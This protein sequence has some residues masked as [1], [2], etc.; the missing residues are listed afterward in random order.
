M[1]DPLAEYR[2]KRR[3]RRTPEPAGDAVRPGRDEL[4]VIQ[5]HHARR[6]HWDV[7][8]ERGGVLVSWAVPKGLPPEPGTVRLAVHTEDH[9][10]EYADFDGEIPAGE[11][12]A[13]TVTIWDRGRYETVKWSTDEVS[14]VLHGDRVRG[15][16]VFFR[17]HRGRG[18]NS[19]SDEWLVRRSDPPQQPDWEPLPESLAP[20]LASAGG[21]PPA[22]RD[23]EWAY[24]FKWDGVRALVRV[25]GGRVTVFSRKG[26]D[27]T[28]SY[29]ELR[30]LGEAMGSTQ[31]MLDG[32]IVAL[33]GGRPNFAALQRRMHV[34]SEASARRLAETQ[35]VTYL[36]FD[37]LHLQGRSLL[38]LPYTERRRQLEG[39]GLA[40]PRWQTPRYFAG[41]GAAVLHASREQGLEGVMAKRLSSPYQAGRRSREWVKVAHLRAQEV[42]I[43]G[44]RPGQGRRAGAIGSLLCGVPAEG[45]LRFVGLVGTGFTEQALAELGS[46]LSRLE[47][48]RCP[49]VAVPR[50]VARQA[51]WVSP[52]LVG[53]VVFREWTRDGRMRGPSW[54]GLRPD[55]SAGEVGL[56]AG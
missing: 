26:N 5:E 35:P 44:W 21:L 13:G 23:A 17:R 32:E 49:F 2:R 38:A 36:V 51:R 10:L 11:Y 54:R 41:G 9:P 25:E 31:A 47:R 19:D 45:G 22:E 56:D 8:L 34:G 1:P 12:G 30:A 46:R 7:R 28:R 14:V 20:M 52:T 50:E 16:Y 43:G 55:K 15:R 3:P 42:V 4:F 6:L 48:R 39:L 37:L 24:E 29:P 18:G 53:E 33:V 27:V 40:G